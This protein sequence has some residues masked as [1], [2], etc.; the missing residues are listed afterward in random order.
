MY[1]LDSLNC[2]LGIVV[3]R[4]HHGMFLSQQKYATEILE[5]ANMSNCKPALT[6]ADTSTK[7]DGTR[8]PVSDPTLYRSLVGALQYLTFTRPD[9]TYLVQHVYLF[10][11]DPREPHFMDLKCI[12]RYVRGTLDHGLQLYVAP[13]CGLIA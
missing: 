6:P 10:M 5:R 2:F 8:H 9:I 11:H 12:W 4:D 3:T 7:F 13:S 1:D